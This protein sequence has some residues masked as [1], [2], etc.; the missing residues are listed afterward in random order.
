MGIIVQVYCDNELVV[1]VWKL[2]GLYQWIAEE[3]LELFISAES[4]VNWIVYGAE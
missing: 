2:L 4:S 1:M 3:M